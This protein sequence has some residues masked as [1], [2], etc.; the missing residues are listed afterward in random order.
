MYAQV[1]NFILRYK[2]AAPDQRM[3]LFILNLE[4]DT[5]LFHFYA[6]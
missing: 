4:K 5:Y 2:M 6:V 1:T 3:K